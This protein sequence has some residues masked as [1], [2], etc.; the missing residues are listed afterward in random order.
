VR[1]LNPVMWGWSHWS[2]KWKRQLNN[3]SQNI[4]TCRCDCQ[5]GFG[6][7]NGFIDHVYRR[8][9]ST[10]RYSTTANLY[11]SQITTAPAKPFPACSSFIICSLA[12][13]SNI[14]DLQLHALT[15]SLRRFLYRTDWVAPVVFRVT[16]WHGGGKLLLGP[17]IALGPVLWLCLMASCWS[18]CH[19]FSA[20]EVF[21]AASSLGTFSCT[22]MAST[23]DEVGSLLSR[24]PSVASWQ[25]FVSFCQVLILLAM[26][27]SWLSSSLGWGWSFHGERRP[28]PAWQLA[29]TCSIMFRHL[30][31]FFRLTVQLSTAIFSPAIQSRWS[32]NPIP[33]L[34]PVVM[35]VWL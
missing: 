17:T 16:S 5:W 27:P 22:A 24:Q 14:G 7:V 32:V 4:V 10:S 9:V 8:L 23:S 33:L 2:L 20:L 18:P 31:H 25:A 6:L 15:S 12:M 35:Y 26:H 30:F 19:F 13:A 21:T 1:V 3:Y 34:T 11:N 28:F 29:S